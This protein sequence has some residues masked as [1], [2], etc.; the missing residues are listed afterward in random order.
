MENRRRASGQLINSMEIE[1]LK[2]VN[3]QGVHVKVSSVFHE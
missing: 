3:K 1:F 2:L